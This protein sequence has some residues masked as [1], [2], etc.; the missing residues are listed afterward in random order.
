MWT[1]QEYVIIRYYVILLTTERAWE[2]RM[3]WIQFS[4]Y[5]GNS[6]LHDIPEYQLNLLQLI[7]NSLAYA[8]VRAPKSSHITPSLQFLHWLK[9]LEWIDYK[10]LSY[11]Q[12]PYY[13]EPSYL[14]YLDLISLQPYRSTRSSDIVTLAC[15]WNNFVKNFANLSMMSHC[16][17]VFLSPVHHHHF[18][19]ALLHLCSIPDSEL[20]KS[21]P[22]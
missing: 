21:F 12:S 8:V 14:Y 2:F 17:L 4:W 22:P 1:W 19:Y 7:Q 6:L 3:S 13:T 10:I 11:L 20:Q 9:I 15:L 16:H 5:S 18:H